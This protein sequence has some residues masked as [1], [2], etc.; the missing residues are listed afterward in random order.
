MACN[1]RTWRLPQGRS[2]GSWPAISVKGVAKSWL[3]SRSTIYYSRSLS[4]LA[5]PFASICEC[6]CVGSLAASVPRKPRV[7][8]QPENPHFRKAHHAA[9]TMRDIHFFSRSRL[10]LWHKGVLL[11]WWDVGDKWKVLCLLARFFPFDSS[12]NLCFAGS[13]Q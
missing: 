10:S 2:L 12:M 13:L 9:K 3:L 4:S 8:R 5:I 11:V 6:S 7:L 1:Y